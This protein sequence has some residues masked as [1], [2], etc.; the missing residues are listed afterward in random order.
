[1]GTL[2]SW[3]IWAIGTAFG[4]ICALIGVIY[5]A[6]QRRDDKQDARA[7]AIEVANQRQDET[8]TATRERLRA[9][10]IE[11]QVL[12]SEVYGLRERWHQQHGE[13]ARALAAW[14]SSLHEQIGRQIEQKM[15]RRNDQ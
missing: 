15:S 14:Y 10:E 9:A 7:E 3:V 5:I 6:S 2:P 4:T 8:A 11:I 13:T 1:M 12:K